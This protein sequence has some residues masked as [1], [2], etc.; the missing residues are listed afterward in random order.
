MRNESAMGE[1]ASGQE[2]TES[3]EFREMVGKYEH[4]I[5]I[6]DK[7]NSL[8]DNEII[9]LLGD[10]QD[11]EEYFEKQIN[12][13]REDGEEI[14]NLGEMSNKTTE[15]KNKFEAEY[16]KRDLDAKIQVGKGEEATVDK[17]EAMKKEREEAGKELDRDYKIVGV[18]EEES[19]N[20]EN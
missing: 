19:E 12:A 17:I 20:E 6:Q 1:V 2:S 13:R 18:D 11:C 3:N 14:N 8:T 15:I 10:A 9:D 5:V 16:D 7:L 4:L